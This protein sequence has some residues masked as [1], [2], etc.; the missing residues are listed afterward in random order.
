MPTS[1]GGGQSTGMKLHVRNAGA[2]TIKKGVIVAFSSLAAGNPAVSFQ[3]GTRAADYTAAAPNATVQQIDVPYVNVVVAGADS[4]TAGAACRL[5]V[6]A[7]DILPGK[8]GEIICY[9]L[10]QVLFAGSITVGTVITSNASGLA[11]AAVYAASKN[12]IGT[13]M[14]AGG[15]SVLGW[16]FVNFLSPYGA[17]AAAGNYNGKGF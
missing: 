2:T 3:D 1:L 6:A 11:T 14:Q 8:D 16:C 4:A 17:A 10:A 12:P 13:A 5:G 9:G 7:A 15:T